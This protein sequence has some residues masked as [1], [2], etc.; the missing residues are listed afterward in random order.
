MTTGEGTAMQL[1]FRTKNQ[2]GASD[3][4]NWKENKLSCFIP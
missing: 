2:A 3:S 1:I 4:Q